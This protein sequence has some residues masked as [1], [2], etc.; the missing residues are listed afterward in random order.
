[1]T[2]LTKRART[3]FPFAPFPDSLTHPRSPFH[4]ASLLARGP[5]VRPR[6]GCG[7]P[8]SSIPLHAA[9]REAI[10][11]ASRSPRT[12]SD[13]YVA[14]ELFFP[15]SIRERDSRVTRTGGKGWHAV[16]AWRLGNVRKKIDLIL[17]NSCSSNILDYC[18]SPTNSP[19]PLDFFV[20]CNSPLLN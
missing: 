8:A 12:L 17:I 18:S 11:Y 3:P 6:V 16:S 13:L 14:R 15:R 4:R 2:G 1:M 5:I 10:A 19:C 20:G 7:T 9:F